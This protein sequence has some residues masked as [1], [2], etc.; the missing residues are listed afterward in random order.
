ME[1][2]RYLFKL[3]YIG[4]KK[5]YGSQRQL[6][7]LT[8]ESCLLNALIEKRYIKSAKSSGFEVA[9]RTDKLVSARGACFS[10][11]TKKI[12]IL[13]EINSNLPKEIGLWAFT[14]VP[15][16]FASRFA[17][18]YRHYK[19]IVLQSF[20]S[21]QTE[22]SFNLDLIKK[23]CNILEGEHD[24]KNFSKIENTI[25]KTKRDLN[26]C[27]ISIK[28]NYI[29]FDFKSKAFLRQQIRRIVKKILEVGSGEI[30]FKEFL[31]LFNRENTISYQPVDPRGLILWDIIFDNTIKFE[32]D[33]PSKKRMLDILLK[34]EMDSKFKYNLFKIFQQNNF[35]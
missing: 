21:L 4:S 5:F 24:F 33:A 35:S 22:F 10:C 1:R 16:N 18:L 9:S 12:P 25:D 17:A 29:I 30:S 13:M 15:L 14:K 23:V 8:V 3:Y 11:I 27:K 19:Y 34:R 6:E 20:P 2:Q 26:E 31:S 28:N 32:E 7:F